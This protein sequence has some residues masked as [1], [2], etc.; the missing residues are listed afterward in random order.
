MRRSQ[1]IAFFVSLVSLTGAGLFAGCGGSNG[2]GGDGGSPDASTDQIVATDTGRDTKG[3]GET[4]TEGGFDAPPPFDSGPQP[5][6]TPP[7]MCPLDG[8]ASPPGTLLEMGA[9]TVWGVTSDG[10]AIYS[11]ATGN[12]KASTVATAAPTMITTGLGTNPDIVISGSAVLVWNNVAAAPPQITTLGVWTHSGGFQMAAAASIPGAAAVSADGTKIIFVSTVD[13]TGKTGNIQGNDTSFA[14]AA[15]TI[16]T[17]VDTDQRAAKCLPNV[18]IVG[19]GAGTALLGSCTAGFPDAAASTATIQS[20]STTTWAPTMLVTGARTPI[21][22]SADT[23]G[24][25]IFTATSAGNA[26]AVSTAGTQTMIDTGGVYAGVMMGDGAHV[27]YGAAVGAATSLKT[28]PTAAPAP[29]VLVATG[30]NGFYGNVGVGVAPDYSHMYVFSIQNAMLGTTDL[31]LAS[32]TVAGTPLSL[33]AQS[34][35]ILFASGW[36]ADSTYALWYGNVVI[37][38]T[39]LY[40]DF[41]VTKVASGT[42]TKLGTLVW[43][44]FALGT[45]G[46]KVTYND[47]ANPN[48]NQTFASTADIRVVDLSQATPTPTLVVPQ[49]DVNYFPSA[50][51]TKLVY[52]YGVCPMV[53]GVY[54]VAS[55]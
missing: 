14:A 3:G 17:G 34:T 24:N 45:T 10:Y 21:S 5:D 19:P 35:G 13:A 52:T 31:S 20:A 7:S 26:V 9:F 37:T 39:G 48:P 8:G 22:Y 23:A 38:G 55:P 25:S 53:N 46:A 47:N 6:V 42:S 41:S 12:L 1:S 54:S 44:D 4:G 43:N 2:S 40:G 50:D 30:V 28:S 33:V 29:T 32:T 16:A 36:S 15:T 51:G 49:A 18:Q 11:D 27:V